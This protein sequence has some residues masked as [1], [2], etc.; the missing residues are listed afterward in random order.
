MNKRKM[1]RANKLAKFGNVNKTSSNVES[2][3]LHPTKKLWYQY[4]LR[5]S[6]A[7]NTAGRK[8]SRSI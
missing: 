6:Q 2:L 5:V 1:A 7:L 3:W 4:Y 8:L